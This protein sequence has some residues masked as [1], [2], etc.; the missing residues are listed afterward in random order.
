[1]SRAHTPMHPCVLKELRRVCVEGPE[2]LVD[3]AYSG[4]TIREHLAGL[5]MQGLLVGPS[6]VSVAYINAKLGLKPDTI[7]A[8]GYDWARCIAECSVAQ[9]DAL[10]AELGKEKS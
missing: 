6:D 1:M 4:L 2:T 10:L 5:A 9:A 3:V 7:C 8:P